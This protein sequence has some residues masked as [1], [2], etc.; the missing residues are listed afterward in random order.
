ML[1]S[2]RSRDCTETFEEGPLVKI[3]PNE[4]FGFLR[5][6]VERPLQLR[7]EITDDTLLA[8]E[9]LKAVGK[10]DSSLRDA[11]LDALRERLGSSFATE[12]L[13]KAVMS[14]ALD[15]AGLGKTATLVKAVTEAIAVRDP[16]A[17]I[18]TD[19]SGNPKPDPDLRDYE[20][21]PLPAVSVAFEDDPTARLGTIEYRTAIDDY[22]ETEVL[23]YVPDAW[24]DP[25]KTK[26]GYEIPLTRHFYTY[27]PPR[28]LTEINAEIKALEAEIQTLLTEVTL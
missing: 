3:F 23:P 11:L 21:I 27:T 20:N 19:R 1:R 22:M 24:Y 6:T 28:P 4:A 14:E 15:S 13:A 9:S 17:P 5:I 2:M 26:I 12:K 18:I 7:W 25:D 8:V 10:L 16:E